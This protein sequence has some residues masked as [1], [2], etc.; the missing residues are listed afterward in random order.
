MA[1]PEDLQANEDYIC[2]VDQYVEIDSEGL[3]TVAGDVYA[4]GCTHSAED[5]L[6]KAL[7]IGF[8][9]MIKALEGG[10]GK[11]IRKV[12]SGLSRIKHATPFDGQL[13]DFGPAQVVGAKP[14]QRFTLLTTVLKNIIDGYDNQVIMATSLKELVQ[15]LDPIFSQFRKTLDKFLEENIAAGDVELLMSALLPLTEIMDRYSKGLKVHELSVPLGLMEQ[16]W[17][18]EKLF[19]GQNTRDED[20]ILRLRDENSDDINKVFLAV[21]SHSKIASKNNLI[22]AILEEYSPNKP[23]NGSIIKFF[24]PI[25][26]KLT[27]LEY[28]VSTK[29]ALKAREEHRTPHQ[30]TLKEVIDSKYTVLDVLSTFFAHA[31]PWVSLAALKVYDRRAYRAYELHAVNY[32]NLDSEPP[33]IVTWDF[34]LKKPSAPATP[35]VERG[36]GFKRVGSISDLSFLVGKSEI[37]PVR[38]GVISPITFLDEAEEYHVRALVLIPL[39]KGAKSTGGGLMVN[40]EEQRRSMPLSALGTKEENDSLPAVC[41]VAVRDAESMDDKHLLERI[42]PLVTDHK[43]ELLLHNVRRITFIC[44]YRD[45]SYP[46][47]FTFCGP[48]YREEQSICHIEPALAFQLELGRLS[49][50]TIK[51]SDKRYFTRAIVRQSRLRDEIPTADYLISETDRLVNDILDPLEIIGNNNSDLNHIFINFTPG[52]P[53]SPEEIEPALGGFTERFGRRLII[54][55]NPK[56]SLAYTLRVVIQNVSRCVIQVEMYAERKTDKGQWVFHSIG[57]KSGSMHLSA[58]NNPYTA[59]EWLQPK[60]HK[61]HLMGKQYVYDFPELFR[62]AFH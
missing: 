19:S 14:P 23:N 33:F 18:I 11:G 51:P 39:G 10:G 59:G 25:L 37:E 52:S 16:Y 61:A 44:G 1:T 40:L 57:T 43:D 7:E 6:Q 50:F 49:N 30:E 3:V 38:K 56:S 31:D 47:Y 53:L 36:D 4:K 13:S 24:R 48:E 9:V 41:N 8:P 15:K 21:L 62:Q 54:C 42:L 22:L 2:I 5:A 45:G 27:E 32:H 17:S 12:D 55:T 35:T 60:S 26:K 20:V 28:R 29:V 34:Q 58:V 46:G